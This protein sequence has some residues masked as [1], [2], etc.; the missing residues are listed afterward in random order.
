MVPGNPP[1]VAVAAGLDDGGLG[2]D[3]VAVQ[4]AIEQVDS[5][6][7]V[8]VLCD[9]GSAVLSAEMALEF[10][11]ET[12]RARVVISPAPLVEGLVV[13][14][15]T[16]AGGAPASEVAAEAANALAGKISQLGGA[17]TTVTPAA[18]AS[19]R[20]SSIRGRRRRPPPW[21]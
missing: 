21:S 4:Q 8:V 6:D 13:A 5:P 12:L 9:L 19:D 14:F 18:A 15:V 16:A 1:A 20:R 7:G 10:L 2:T 17:A 11:D 3:A